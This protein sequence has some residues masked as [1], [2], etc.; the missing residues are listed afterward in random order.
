MVQY[1]LNMDRSRY[2][3]EV[4]CLYKIESEFEDLL[5]SNGINVRYLAVPGQSRVKLVWAVGRELSKANVDLIHVF[6][7]T[8]AYYA[9]FAKAFFRM[10][11]P[12]LFSSGGVTMTLTGQKAMFRYGLGRYAYPIICNSQTV[13]DWWTGIGVDPPLLRVIQNG[14]DLR[15]YQRPVNTSA[16]RSELGV[17]EG[18]TLILT[19]GRLISTKRV[20]D[21]LHAFV[22]LNKRFPDRL[23]LAI[24]GDGPVMES[25]VELSKSLGIEDRVQFLGSRSDV[26]S[27]LKSADI[28]AFPSE[29]EGLPNAVI[30]ASLAGT[31]IVGSNIGPVTEVVVDRESALLCDTRS[32][33][34]L[35]DRI[36]ELIDNPKRGIELAANAKREAESRFRL[37]NTLQKIDEAYHDAISDQR[38]RL[39]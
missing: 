9:V 32:P 11:T 16:V 18:E 15:P 37:E 30:E 35:A 23:R 28:F 27:L 13:K 17:K 3:I 14:H 25:L 20:C 8:V 38:G 39:S 19:V 29:S 21:L 1:C 34:Q 22:D 2:Q 24:A 12:I 31:P 26:I 5:D 4:W 33:D 10:K 36:S 7:P 6:L